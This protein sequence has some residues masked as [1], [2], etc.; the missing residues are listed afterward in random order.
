MG[1]KN[2][3]HTPKLAMCGL[4]KLFSYK[5]EKCWQNGGGSSRNESKTISPQVAHGDINNLSKP[6]WQNNQLS[7][8]ISNI[9]LFHTA[10]QLQR[11]NMLWTHKT[12]PMLTLMGMPLGVHCLCFNPLRAK[13][14]PVGR[15][16]KSALFQIVT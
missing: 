8:M 11:Q 1:A 9:M 12:H 5:I 15:I 16:D 2:V 3:P 7:K 14:I 10:W 4:D 13:F 6:Q